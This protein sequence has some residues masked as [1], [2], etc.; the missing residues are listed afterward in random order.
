MD[1]LLAPEL[2]KEKPATFELGRA[3]A[4][5]GVLAAEY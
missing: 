5:A 1:R 2:E 4:L 3:R